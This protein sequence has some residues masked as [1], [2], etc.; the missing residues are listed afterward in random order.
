MG[1]N[2]GMTA[3]SRL[4]PIFACPR[5]CVK[6][7]Q[8]SSHPV[9]LKD[10][11]GTGIESMG[12]SNAAHPSSDAWATPAQAELLHINQVLERN[13]PGTRTGIYRA[14]GRRG[15]ARLPTP[16]RTVRLLAIFQ[17]GHVTTIV[18]P[19]QADSVRLGV[20]AGSGPPP[21]WPAR[22][23]GAQSLPG[24]EERIRPV[25]L[26]FSEKKAVTGGNHE[27][28]TVLHVCVPPGPAMTQPKQFSSLR[29]R[30]DGG[31]GLIPG[32]AVCPGESRLAGVVRA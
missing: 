19:D 26:Q 3:P 16:A 8:R 5:I 14:D 6:S 15:A 10:L 28:T 21:L 32:G 29:T 25:A 11:I 7:H 13:D 31:G 9:S 17:N 18:E 4:Q 12:S 24:E 30:G 23:L 2:L 20:K 27:G 22:Q 1:S